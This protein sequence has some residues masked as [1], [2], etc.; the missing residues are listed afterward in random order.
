M[1]ISYTFHS[2]LLSSRDMI[3]YTNSIR[4][5]ARCC[6]SASDKK[7]KSNQIWKTIKK[8]KNVSGT[9]KA[10]DRLGEIKRHQSY[11]LGYN[12][13]LNGVQYMAQLMSK[14]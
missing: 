9:F 1:I 5:L 12:A 3:F 6:Q 14:K 11:T 2:S 7:S 8:E 10:I 4:S 13:L